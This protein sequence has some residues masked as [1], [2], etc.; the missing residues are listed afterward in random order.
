MTVTKQLLHDGMQVILVGFFGYE[1]MDKLLS[2][3]AFASWCR[4]LPYIGR[5]APLTAFCV[6]VVEILIILLVLLGR[7]RLGILL[8]LFSILLFTSYQCVA[9][10]NNWF[11][12]PFHPYWEGMT[13][14]SKVLL[15]LGLGWGCW[16]WIN[17]SYA[18]QSK[19][20]DKPH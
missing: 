7:S 5:W 10:L 13:W 11:Y 19:N 3:A 17:M 9:L 15:V 18:G 8:A 6:V 2:Y 14:L 1:A 4:V 12:L 16:W 20:H